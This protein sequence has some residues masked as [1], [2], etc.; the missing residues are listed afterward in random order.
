MGARRVWQILFL[1]RAGLHHA[2]GGPNQV[3]PSSLWEV[4][5]SKG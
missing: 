4:L 3:A 2:R 5:V 1:C